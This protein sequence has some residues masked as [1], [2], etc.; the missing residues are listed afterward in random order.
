MKIIKD[1]AIYLLGELISKSIPFMMLP[2]L[3]R[4]LESSGF[5]ELSIYQLYISIFV[6]FIGFSQEGAISRYYFRYGTR[7]LDSLVFT[8]YIFSFFILIFFLVI[9][10][11][12]N[13]LLLAVCALISFLQFVFTVQ[14]T[15][16]QCKKDAKEYFILQFIYSFSYFLFTYLLFEFW[17]VSIRTVLFS[18]ILCSLFSVFI[19][20]IYTLKKITSSGFKFKVTTKLFFYLISFG[21]PLIIHQLSIL[22]KGQFDR[23]VVYN[24][25]SSDVLGKYAV[26]YQV[27]SVIFVILMALN[28]AIVP[29]YFSALKNKRINFSHLNKF[30]I[31]SLSLLPVT[32]F[33]LIKLVPIGFLGWLL[34]TEFEEARVFI[35][36]FSSGFILLIPY[37]ALVNYLFYHG[38]TKVIATMSVIASFVYVLWL[39]Y[40]S[41]KSLLSVSH[42]MLISN[43]VLVLVLYFYSRQFSHRS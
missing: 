23:F 42:S 15:I 13:Y 18:L 34:G 21:I 30:V 19:S 26:A 14:L 27:S 38:K 16:R 36:I 10:I 22:V 24:S 5:G 32:Y 37:L 17:D 41:S 20:S 33:F 40:S 4:K 43:S 1:S 29:Y 25:Y 35:P 28:K 7:N 11:A 12:F 31:Y 39:F 8:S 3:T 6:I 9:S 2:Y